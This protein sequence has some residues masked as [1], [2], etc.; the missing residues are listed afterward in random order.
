MDFQE[1]HD[2]LTNHL[3]ASGKHRA[4]PERFAILDAVLQSQGHFDAE[5]LYYRMITNGVK[6][7]K[8]TVYNT[9]EILQDCGLVSKYRFAEN[10]SRYEKAFGRPHHHHMICLNCGDIIEFVNDKIE[11]IQ[12]EACNEKNFKVQSTTIQIF[13][14]CSKCTKRP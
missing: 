2:I 14:T 5:S 13:G 12:E 7:S 9:L 3:K 1:A 11:R 6:V 8:A 10:T 4:T